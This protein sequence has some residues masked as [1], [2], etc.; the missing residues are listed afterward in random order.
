MCSVGASRPPSQRQRPSRL[1]KPKLPRK[2][3]PP[4]LGRWRRSTKRNVLLPRT[5]RTTPPP[6]LFPRVLPLLLRRSL[7]RRPSS[8]VPWTKHAPA[9]HRG[10]WSGDFGF[11]GVDFDVEMWAN[12]GEKVWHVV[13]T[14]PAFLVSSFAKKES[15]DGRVTWQVF[16]CGL[17]SPA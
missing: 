7:E 16:T 4:F 10:L 1:P 3:R 15:R 9:H 5:Q 11:S 13:C 17:L 6:R 12:L 8:D 2:L 14:C